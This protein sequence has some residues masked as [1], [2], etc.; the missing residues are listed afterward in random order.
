MS[1]ARTKL[2]DTLPPLVFGTATF[3]FQFNPDPFALPTTH[4]VHRALSLGVR[5]FDTS[6]YYGPAEDLL[7]T[8]LD[9]DVVRSHFPRTSYHILTKVGRI[10]SNEFD[11]S[12]AWVRHSVRRSLRRLRTSYLDVVYCHDAEFVSA[13]EV[14]EAI[15]ELRR[16]RDEEG[17]VKYVGISGYPVHGLCDLAEL[18]LRETSEPLDAVMSYANFTLQNTR[19]LSE[20]I[21]RLVAA[22]V[23]VVPN[24]SPLGM[25]LLRRQGVPIGAMGNWHPAPDEL[26]K[27]VQWASQWTDKQGEKLEVVA[28]R[29]ALESWLREAA[30]V[31]TYGDPLGAV[32]TTFASGLP[33]QDKLGVS[34]MGVSNLEEL[35][36]TMRV[37]RSVLDGLADDLDREPGSIT[38]S[39]A[40]TDHEW[41]L[42]RRQRI[43][44]LA[45][46]IRDVIGNYTD[47]TW[48]SPGKDFVNQRTVKGVIDPEEASNDVET[49]AAML[50]P[51]SEAED[52]GIADDV[53]VMDCTID[54]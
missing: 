28:V 29:F 33:A 44:M 14:L 25:G 11:Y 9:T 34:V 6:P 52:D 38:P 36:E 10:A 19:L 15:R 23:D 46:G 40:V 48:E 27:A 22:G 7:G 32:G 41:S 37:W 43:R 39:D 13:A 21:P 42:Q 3:N 49:Q 8:A 17:T 4:L 20:G 51:P 5:A 1:P 12:P 16:I 24:A 35:D 18:V 45:K 53:P 47:F 2:S 54:G 30:E 26:R 31:G 50:T